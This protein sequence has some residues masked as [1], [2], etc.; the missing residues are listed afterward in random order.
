MIT[1]ATTG[2]VDKTST[3]NVIVEAFAARWPR[4]RTHQ[5]RV[6]VRP[7]Q[8]GFATADAVLPAVSLALV[9]AHM[10]LVAD[11]DVHV[12]VTAPQIVAGTLTGV[13]SMVLVEVGGAAAIHVAGAPFNAIL[14]VLRQIRGARTRQVL[15]AAAEL[16]QIRAVADTR[17]ALASTAT[18]T[19]VGETSLLTSG[20]ST[21]AQHG[22]RH[23]RQIAVDQVAAA[24]AF[25]H[26]ECGRVDGRCG[27]VGERQVD[28]IDR[29]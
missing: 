23:H 3:W 12:G 8:V 15:R 27:G 1:S 10:I 19:R 21:L 13:L 18:A 16:Y 26:A 22:R 29:G 14:T 4:Q 25:V 24:G 7:R 11:V 9:A 2:S 6:T 5:V 20:A 17:A 28:E